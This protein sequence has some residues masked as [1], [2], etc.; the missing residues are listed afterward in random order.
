MKKT[1]LAVV[2]M[3]LVVLTGI[4]YSAEKKKSTK[5][6]AATPA[7]QAAPAT[8][9]PP[10]K[11]KPPT[12]DF[13]SVPFNMETAKIPADF[14]GHDIEKLYNTFKNKQSGKK[15]EFETTEQYQK[16]LEAEKDKPLFG[17][18]AKDSILA[19]VV[20]ANSEYNADEQ[21]M[22][23]SLPTTSV[24]NSI[25]KDDNK[26]GINIKYGANTTTTSSGQNA[27]GAK[28]DIEKTH[29][30][31]Y[32][33]A[34]HNKSYLPT[35]KTLDER[36]KKSLEGSSLRNN[37]DFI[38]RMKKTTYVHKM[39]LGTDQAREVKPNL[40]AIVLAIPT[41]PY[42]SDGAIL[43]EATFKDPKE[44]FSQM[45]YLNVDIVQIWFYNKATGEILGKLTGK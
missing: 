26:L 42:T 12:P 10:A 4:G 19:F 20:K 9:T 18:V 5:K 1:V 45:Y 44:F 38:E 6:Q 40:G 13:L 8:P 25:K 15:D 16:R 17:T 32:E 29:V 36:L 24:Y 34:I 31:T 33:L 3:I 11:P 41:S 43:R 27:Y 39:K 7:D 21:I 30:Q 37:N 23:V 14:L 2:V 22:T 35:E 28:V